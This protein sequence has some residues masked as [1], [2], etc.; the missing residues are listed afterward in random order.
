MPSTIIAIDDSVEVLLSI[1]ATLEPDYDIRVATSGEEG[2]ALAAELRPDLILLDIMMPDIDG[3]EICRRLQ[4]DQALKD[5][6][7]I[8]LTSLGRQ[9]DEVRCFETGGVDFVTKPFSPIVLRS[10]VATQVRLKQQAE[11][12]QF[13]ATRDGL[14]G[15]F[16]RREF[17]ALLDRE[18]RACQQDHEQLAILMMDIDHFKLYNNSYGHQ[19]GDR[20]LQLVAGAVRG[21][22][23]RGRD[24]VARYGG[25]EFVCLLP[26]T[27]PQAAQLIGEKILAAVQALAIPHAASLTTETVSISVGGACEALFTGKSSASLLKRADDSLYQAKE[28]GRNRLIFHRC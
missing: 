2:L 1:G 13:Q 7:V 4:Q 27:N 21:Q 8:F 28:Q 17:N 18:W 9:E 23:K 19:K 11:L 12:L 16:N 15:L 5:I 20:C 10:R 22:L 14:T 26:Q 25:E 24:C 6:P 3:L